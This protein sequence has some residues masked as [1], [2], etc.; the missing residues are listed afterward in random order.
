ML[1]KH[2]AITTTSKIIIKKTQKMFNN[3]FIINLFGGSPINNFD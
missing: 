2:V 3:N 1:K